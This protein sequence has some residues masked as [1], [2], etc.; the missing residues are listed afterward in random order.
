MFKTEHLEGRSVY[1][2]DEVVC[3]NIYVNNSLTYNSDTFL[4]QILV[5]LDTYRFA[6]N[7]FSFSINGKTISQEDVYK[8][9]QK[10]VNDYHQV[11]IGLG[12]KK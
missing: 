8:E 12:L 2:T 6:Y 10:G 1:E 3:I 4:S 7:P 5:S 9:L 11:R